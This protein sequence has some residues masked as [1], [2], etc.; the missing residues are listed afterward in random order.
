MIAPIPEPSV[1]QWIYEVLKPA[2][3]DPEPHATM[4]SATRWFREHIRSI[5]SDRI[6]KD[7]EV[8]VSKTQWTVAQMLANAWERFPL[9]C[10][11]RDAL[12][13]E[14]NALRYGE[15]EGGKG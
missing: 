8:A 6:L 14:W 3:A 1:Q 9:G 2:E 10:G 11:E 7:C 15:A 13:A 5:P 12:V 4:R